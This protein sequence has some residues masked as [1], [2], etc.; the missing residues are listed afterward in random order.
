MAPR[1]GRI[2]FRVGWRA[3]L[4][5]GSGIECLRTRHPAGVARQGSRQALPALLDEVHLQLYSLL[6]LGPC[7]ALNMG[8]HLI[9]HQVYQRP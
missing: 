7:R 3:R 5:A 4:R 1:T 2:F 6:G 9:W 8:A